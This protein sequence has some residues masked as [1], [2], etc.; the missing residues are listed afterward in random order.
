[1]APFTPFFMNP[2]MAAM[3]LLP[4]AAVAAVTAMY[5]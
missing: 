4:R 2:A 1:M 3:P 5:R